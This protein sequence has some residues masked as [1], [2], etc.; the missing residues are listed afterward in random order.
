QEFA[1]LRVRGFGAGDR[2]GGVLAGELVS[3]ELL[4]DV[5]DPSGGEGLPAAGVCDRRPVT[6][7]ERDAKVGAEPLRRRLHVDPTLAP[8]GKA[9][10]VGSGD[11]TGVVV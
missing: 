1:A 10:E 6:G 9:V 8:V 5:A 11:R 3:D 2:R 4:E 7:D